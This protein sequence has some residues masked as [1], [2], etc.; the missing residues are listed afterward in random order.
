MILQK[1]GFGFAT[2]AGTALAFGVGTLMNTQQAKAFTLVVNPTSNVVTGINN[3]SISGSLYN[4][5][6]VGGSFLSIF[7]S[8]TSP[9]RPV[10][11]L[12]NPSGAQQAA[13]AIITA[14]GSS[15]YTDAFEFDGETFFFDTFLLPFNITANP[16]GNVGGLFTIASLTDTGFQP[17]VDGLGTI[18]LNENNFLEFSPYAVLTPVTTTPQTVPEPFVGGAILGLSSLALLSRRQKKRP[19]EQKEL[20][21]SQE[22]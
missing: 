15:A 6:F 12:G 1:R 9:N 18:F 14:L 20:K 10:P 5:N 21:V 4:V 22:G 7:G 13:Q 19:V 17:G 3:L 8:P 16:R 11:F 2:I